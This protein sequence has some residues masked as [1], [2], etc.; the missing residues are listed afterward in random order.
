MH[1][2]VR[3]FASEQSYHAGVGGYDAVGAQL[4]EHVNLLVHLFH[5]RLTRVDVEGVI[6][7]DVRLVRLFDGSCEAFLVEP[8]GS[9]PEVQPLAAQIHGVRAIEDGGLQF[10]HIPCRGEQLWCIWANVRHGGR[11]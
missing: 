1:R 11:L 3:Q 10:L 8:S 2:D 5:V 4:A 9:G 7:L 6:H